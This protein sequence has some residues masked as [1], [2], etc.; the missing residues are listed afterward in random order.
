MSITLEKISADIGVYISG[1]HRFGTDAALLAEFAAPRKSDKAVDL[2]TGCGIIPMLWCR[3]HEFASA[4]GVEISQAAADLAKQTAEEYSKGKVE[5]IC[6][7]LRRIEDCL[8]RERFSLVSCN[9]PYFKKGSGME[10]AGEKG[11]AR[12]DGECSMEDLAKAADYLLKYGGRLCLCQRPERLCDVFWALRKYGIEPKVLQ[13]VAKNC[14]T[15][16]WLCLIEAKKGG[17]PG[18]KILPTKI[19]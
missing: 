7:D 15:N 6:A 2:G 11:V 3:D 9:P 18:L 1:D 12:H 19:V 4:V 17:R 14:E 5:I 16:P 13:N 10:R 8:P